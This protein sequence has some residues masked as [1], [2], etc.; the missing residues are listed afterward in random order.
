MEISSGSQVQEE[1]N[2][3]SKSWALGL[4]ALLHTDAFP[5]RCQ[6]KLWICD[7]LIGLCLGVEGRGSSRL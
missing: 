5:L 2:Q 1:Q 6:Q 7:T 3:A 4:G